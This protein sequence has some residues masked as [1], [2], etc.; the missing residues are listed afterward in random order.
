MSIPENGF[1]PINLSEDQQFCNSLNSM[2]DKLKEL[3]NSIVQG[4][5]SYDPLT[6]QFHI[7][8]SKGLWSKALYTVNQLVKSVG[9]GYQ[10][11]PI[12]TIKLDTLLQ[13]VNKNIQSIQGY[14]SKSHEINAVAGEILHGI[15]TLEESLRKMSLDMEKKH[16]LNETD[17]T[18][19]ATQNQSLAELKRISQKTLS[20]ITLL[21]DEI[22]LI[23]LFNS[24]DDVSEFEKIC[25]T[26][27]HLNA[28][29]KDK[30]I[31]QKLCSAGLP[32]IDPKKAIQFITTYGKELKEID[33]SGLG[34]TPENL[35]IILK[36]CPKLASLKFKTVNANHLIALQRYNQNQEVKSLKALDLGQYILTEKY[37]TYLQGIP[38][39]KLSFAAADSFSD[40][41]L[42]LL[43]DMPLE[44]LSIRCGRN[45]SLTDEGVASLLKEKS[46]KKLS[47]VQVP[48]GEKTLACLQGKK[49]EE[50]NLKKCRKI[51]GKDLSNLVGMPLKKLILQ[52]CNQI[53]SGL[54]HIKDLPLERLILKNCDIS[55]DNLLHL[56]GLPLKELN[57]FG[58]RRVTGRGLN[59]IKDMPLEI[60]NLAHCSIKGDD[61]A[62]I[63]GK[64]LQVL[65]LE[66]CDLRGAFLHHLTD[67]PINELNL[68]GHHFSLLDILFLINLKLPLSHLN[69]NERRYPPV[70]LEDLLPNVKISTPPT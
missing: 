70:D 50:L 60:L 61:L 56:Q 40:N 41:G 45:S 57:L 30:N 67:L 43:K 64:P 48:I 6:R 39:Q 16:L 19:L 20:P 54:I 2:S 11:K 10:E 8:D 25:L 7:T 29:V 23:T 63:K 47:L 42:V 22:L 1:Q 32:G 27:R 53:E 5:A 36:A 18:I 13:D 28:L 26:N 49:L 51:T 68:Y 52:N 37:I 55:D 12:K 31:I 15:E 69:I 24:I 34:I 14:L 46:L 38:L 35:A 33:F 66:N 9:W 4:N 44:D 59:C 58:C 3:D 62:L 21:P 17:L 65:S